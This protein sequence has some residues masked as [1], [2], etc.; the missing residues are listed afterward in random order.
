[1]ASFSN[2]TESIESEDKVNDLVE[3]RECK[4]FEERLA[5]KGIVRKKL[6]SGATGIAFSICNS[7]SKK[8][9]KKRKHLRSMKILKG[10]TPELER[11]SKL[12]FKIN[13]EINMKAQRFTPHVNRVESQ[14]FCPFNKDILKNQP[15]KLRIFF[16][17]WI[18][19]RKLDTDSRMGLTVM[20]LGDLDFLEFVRRGKMKS[21]REMK[22]MIFQVV[23]TLAVLQYHVPGFK[24][25]DLKENNVVVYNRKNSPKGI[26]EYDFCGRKFRL[27]SKT[28]RMKIIDFDLAMTDEN[29]NCKQPLPVGY[30]T[31]KSNKTKKKKK[32]VCDPYKSKSWRSHGLTSEYKPFYDLHY[33][34]NT[35]LEY[36][37][38][39]TFEYYSELSKMLPVKFL[40]HDLLDERGEFDVISKWRLVI[41]PDPKTKNL[42]TPTELL[43]SGYFDDLAVPDKKA[44]KDI[45]ES[46][47]AGMDLN[48]VLKRKKELLYNPDHEKY[49]IDQLASSSFTKNNET[50]NAKVSSKKSSQKRTSLKI[51]IVNHTSL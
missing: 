10:D 21:V 3:L 2:V 30:E 9:C 49:I 25:G 36:N 8:L 48:E 41:F 22:E 50:T 23:Y 31:F 40:T 28:P 35:L 6:G 27:N 24:H 39:P 5:K 20:E 19:K 26:V 29:L 46:Y 45:V 4:T 16:K 7:D 38:M 13:R 43:L 11:A 34:L 44:G 33:F 51:P 47:E 32:H 42:Y 37:T 14:I 18:R 12:D 15:K 1:M 17:E